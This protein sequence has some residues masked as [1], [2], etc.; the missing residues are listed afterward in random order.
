M[1]LAGLKSTNG[2]INTA[3]QWV[4]M[5][6]NDSATNPHVHA[7]IGHVLENLKNNMTEDEMGIHIEVGKALTLENIVNEQLAI[8]RQS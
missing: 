1:G 5:A 8:R 6:L 7:A 2:D 4:G 3:L